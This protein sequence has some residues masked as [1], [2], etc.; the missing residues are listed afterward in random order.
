[1]ENSN[2]IVFY[3][4]SLKAL[5]VEAFGANHDHCRVLY[6]GKTINLPEKYLKD[7]LITSEWC[8]LFEEFEEDEI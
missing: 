7:L 4:D 6:F 1:M 2:I 8:A 3:G 5:Q